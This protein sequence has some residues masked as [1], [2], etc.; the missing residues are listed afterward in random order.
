MKVWVVFLMLVLVHQPAAAEIVIDAGRLG[1]RLH[2]GPV[3]L[4]LSFP[5]DEDARYPERVRSHA[6]ALGEMKAGTLRWPMGTLAD[7]YLWHTPGGYES[8]DEGLKPCVASGKAPADWGYCTNPDG[9][10]KASA[11]D[12][13]EFIALC[14]ELNAEPVVMVNALG[15]IH[16]GA[17]YDYRQ[18]KTSAVE[19]VKYAKRKNYQVKYWE[20]GNEVS[21]PIKKGEM[22]VGDYVALFNDFTTAMKQADPSVMTGLGLGFG[23]FKEVLDAT[24][25][26]A[27][28]IVPHVYVSGYPSY[29]DYA[30]DG[31][32]IQLRSV[33]AAQDAIDAQPEPYRSKLRILVTEFSSYSPQRRWDNF[34][35]DIGKSLVTFDLAATVLSGYPSVDYL[36]FW[37]TH[38]PWGGEGGMKNDYANALDRYLNVLPQ[39]RALGVFNRF[40]RGRM[41]VLD[42]ARG[43]LRVFATHSPSAGTLS[44]YLL[45]KST[46]P[47]VRTVRLKNYDG[48]RPGGVWVYRGGGSPSSLETTLARTGPVAVEDGVFEITLPPVSVSVAAFGF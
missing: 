2:D 40:A 35:N 42:P 46:K 4:C 32:A 3:G 11:M 37:V 43:K 7:N 5:T 41:V 36:H 13:D 1:A 33:R 28:F 8:V 22:S 31:R 9:T 15:H 27:D 21:I 19:L 48:S 45:N 18:I 16:P 23:Y 25:E 17:K 29:A 14:R 10:I 26:R 6:E 38:S 12:F 34:H 47:M 39:G 20:I 30:N 44:I 24:R